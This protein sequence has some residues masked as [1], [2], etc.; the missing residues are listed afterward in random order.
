MDLRIHISHAVD[1][2]KEQKILKDI[3]NLIAKYPTNTVTAFD[4]DSALELLER[5]FINGSGAITRQL[6]AKNIKQLKIGNQ[7]L[8]VT[9]IR[10]LMSK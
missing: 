5:T 3:V 8:S 1:F 9:G 10:Q 4:Y 6:R 7:L 2:E